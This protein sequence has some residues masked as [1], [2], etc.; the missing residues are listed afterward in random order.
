M[1]SLVICVIVAAAI[2]WSGTMVASAM[3]A[4]GAAIARLGQQVTDLLDVKAKKKAKTRTSTPTAPPP[5]E[6]SQ[7]NY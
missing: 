5:R 6:P 7:S 2:P 3:P 4:E 1:R